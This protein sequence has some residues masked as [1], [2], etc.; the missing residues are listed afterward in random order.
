MSLPPCEVKVNHAK[1]TTTKKNVRIYNKTE[2]FGRHRN[3]LFPFYFTLWWDK[4][5]SSLKRSYSPHKTP[6]HPWQTKPAFLLWKENIFPTLNSFFFYILGQITNKT[7][8]FSSAFFFLLSH[9]FF[10]LFVLESPSL[11]S[12]KVIF[13]ALCSL[14]SKAFIAHPQS[15]VHVATGQK[16]CMR[17]WLEGASWSW[18]AVDWSKKT[19]WDLAQWHPSRVSREGLGWC[20]AESMS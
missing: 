16:A 14:I 15:R 1:H 8:P 20:V 12:V 13:P 7:R 3:H 11:P 18:S 19:V 6:H 4:Q 10:S 9:V 17:T 5:N 2:T